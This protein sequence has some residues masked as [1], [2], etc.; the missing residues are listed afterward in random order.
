[1]VVSKAFTNY[2]RFRIVADATIYVFRMTN[3]FEPSLMTRA[4]D[5]SYFAVGSFILV[6]QVL[7]GSSLSQ[8]RLDPAGPT[9][10]IWRRGLPGL[11]W[12]VVLLARFR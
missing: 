11:P 1:M 5:P 9:A 2:I 3:Q 8:H 10:G 4:Q 7:L 12:L 6:L